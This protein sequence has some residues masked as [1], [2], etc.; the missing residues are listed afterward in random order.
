MIATVKRLSGNQ[1]APPDMAIATEL[2]AV[3][4]AVTHIP[5]EP[6]ENL[7]V[8]FTILGCDP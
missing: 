5:S 6:P 2:A 1:P 8:P 4:A 7:F 3:Q